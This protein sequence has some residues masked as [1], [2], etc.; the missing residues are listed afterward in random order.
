MSKPL[1]EYLTTEFKQVASA[2]WPDGLN[3]VGFGSEQHRDMVRLYLAGAFVMDKA[4]SDELEAMMMEAAE[5]NWLPGDEWNWP[6]SQ[7][8]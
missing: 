5:T 1:R 8:N 6:V 4:K 3:V 2:M 7:Q